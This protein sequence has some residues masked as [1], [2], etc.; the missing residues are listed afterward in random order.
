MPTLRRQKWAK[1]QPAVLTP[2]LLPQVWTPSLKWCSIAHMLYPKAKG[3]H[4]M[5]A[6]E[7]LLCVMFWK[8]D[9][10]RCML[11][12]D[13]GEGSDSVSTCLSSRA[14][15]F[16]CMQGLSWDQHL[17][18]TAR[19]SPSSSAPTLSLSYKAPPAPPKSLM[20]VGIKHRL[21]CKPCSGSELTGAGQFER[22]LKERNVESDM[23]FDFL[24]HVLFF[25]LH[26]VQG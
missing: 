8:Q 21:F 2:K 19:G 23:Y 25:C 7:C 22:K 16:W 1:E 15:S 9:T 6:R 26:R 11:E 3:T 14:S 24:P 4:I 18:H 17:E 10:K 13:N 20:F 12:A 5:Q